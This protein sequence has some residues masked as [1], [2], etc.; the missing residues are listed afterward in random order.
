MQGSRCTQ[1]SSCHQMLYAA[2]SERLK[3]WL[4]KNGGSPN[5]TYFRL[6]KTLCIA[7]PV[8]KSRRN[9]DCQTHAALLQSHSTLCKLM[10]TSSPTI[11]ERNSPSSPSLHDIIF[12]HY[13][14]WHLADQLTLFLDIPTEGKRAFLVLFFT[15]N[16][17]D[18][19]LQN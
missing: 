1:N 17:P 9:C 4:D 13:P 8:H 15:K 16:A 5:A 7:N 11:P 10:C 6:K 19:D 3:Y 12:V 2:R 18:Q 14:I